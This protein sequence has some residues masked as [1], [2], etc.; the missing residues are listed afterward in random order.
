MNRT[1]YSVSRVNAYIN[2][3]FRAD[4]VLLRV[5]VRGEV[6]NASYSS[7]GHIFF[8]LKDEESEITCVM[9]AGDR[10]GMSF[11][12]KD[13]DKVVVTGQVSV[14][15]QKG[16][17]QLYAK[18]IEQEGAGVLYAR[19]L[20][21]KQE[22]EDMG[23][24]APEY[25]KPIPYYVRKL[26]VVTASTGAAVHDIQT[27]TH[28]R[29][30]F[31]QVILCPAQVQGKGAAES[32]VHGIEVLD[33]MGLDCIIVGR[34]GGSIE[35]L[36]AFNEEIVARAI[37]DADTPIISAVG[38]ETDTTIADYVADMRAP[39]PSAGAELAVLDV[40]ELLQKLEGSRQ[41]LDTGLRQRIRDL[42]ADLDRRG[43][44]IRMLSPES[45]IREKRMVLADYEKR[46]DA[47]I[48]HSL[49]RTEKRLEDAGRSLNRGMDSRLQTAKHQ[50]EVRITRWEGLSP[51][52]KLK[53]G[54]SYAETESGRN[55]SSVE[56]IAAGQTYL[57]HVTDGTITSRAEAVSRRTD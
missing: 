46:M 9:F 17:Y 24:F 55:I 23:M 53:M 50:L 32:I 10:G 8:T 26:G 20:A 39:T 15:A 48:D 38:H 43:E 42:R 14:Y 4:P 47:G 51:L 56:D 36:W 54:Y 31:V 33:R 13:G 21:L 1:V 37:F 18:T 6:S 29:N 19:F 40:R 45:Q 22:L 35:D 52:R 25:K 28:R 12:M 57:L 2:Q 3:M 27:I 49:E 44:K 5:S 34:G 30:P 41:M 16:R 11:R 7:R